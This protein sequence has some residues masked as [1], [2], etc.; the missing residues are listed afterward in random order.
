MALYEGETLHSK[1]AGG[2]LS[3]D[4]AL[5]YG[6]DIAQGL[7]KAHNHGIVH[8]DIKPEII[9]LTAD[10]FIKILD[11]G[12]AKLIYDPNQAEGF[13]GTP[14]YMAPEQIRGRSDR[15][16]DLWALGVVMYEMVTGPATRLPETRLPTSCKPLRTT[17]SF[18]LRTC[19][20]TPPPKSKS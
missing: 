9:F 11:F 16:T 6:I 12:L 2:P 8:R 14:D 13:L 17:T 19:A 20:S 7:A 3:V 18:L 1:L 15:R 5:K 4:E 10:G